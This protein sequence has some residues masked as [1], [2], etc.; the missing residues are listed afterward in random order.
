MNEKHSADPTKKERDARNL[1]PIT[2]AP[3]SH[4]VG[5]GVGA[6]VGGVAG[7]AAAAATA[8]MTGAAAGTVIGG[9]IGA[10]GGLIVGAVVGASVGKVA[11]EKIDPTKEA[12]YWREQYRSEPYYKSSYS[13]E[14]YGPA[15]GFG[16]NS[17]MKYDDEEFDAM[18]MQLRKEYESSRVSKMP[19]D[20]AKHPAK[21]AWQHV[22]H[23]QAG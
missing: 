22:R 9:P 23:G 4:P 16:V 11:A 10:V 21:S 19:W 12:S 13:Y 8:A 14:D 6:A 7:V 2:D 5:T 18:D 1:D 3:G 20:D 17:A 15:Y